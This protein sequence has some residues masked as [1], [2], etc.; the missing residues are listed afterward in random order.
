MDADFFSE[1][2][3]KYFPIGS[4]IISTVSNLIAL[5]ATY[6]Q[7]FKFVFGFTTII[8]IAFLLFVIWYSTKKSIYPRDNEVKIISCVDNVSILDN[9][10]NNSIWKRKLTLEVCQ[11]TDSYCL[12]L[13]L[14]PGKSTNFAAYFENSPSIMLTVHEFFLG[15]TKYLKVNFIN[16]FKKKEIIKDLVIRWDVYEGF[17]K[18]QAGITIDAEPGQEKSQIEIISKRP[19]NRDCT[20]MVL[21]GNNRIPISQGS[22]RVN[23]HIDNNKNKEYI[24]RHDFSHQISKTTERSFAL[25]WYH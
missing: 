15:S 20:W 17:T 25:A 9:K 8:S 10:G 6:K 5:F 4:A 12:F 16:K 21:Y 1:K 19:I 23:H 13:P 3:N 7:E 14:G 2:L 11:E 24:I 22:L 18:S